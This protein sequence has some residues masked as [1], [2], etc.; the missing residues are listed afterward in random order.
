MKNILQ[1]EGKEVLQK[2]LFLST[3]NKFHIIS[4]P[5]ETISIYKRIIRD[6]KNLTLTHGARFLHC[7]LR[8]LSELEKWHITVTGLSTEMGVSRTTVINHLK[9]L[10]EAG[11]LETERIPK[12][13]NSFIWIVYP[14]PKK[15][16]EKRMKDLE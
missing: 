1:R 12:T 9:E 15:Q 4:K 10:R 13:P 7:L 8:V 2:S 11:L 16:Y 14:L 6:R 3:L 5:G